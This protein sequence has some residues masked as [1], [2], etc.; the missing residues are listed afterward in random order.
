MSQPDVMLTG[1]IGGDDHVDFNNDEI[2]QVLNQTEHNMGS[3]SE[4]KILLPNNNKNSISRNTFNC[5]ATA[6]N[7]FYQIYEVQEQV[8]RSIDIAGCQDFD[9]I[10]YFNYT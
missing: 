8:I 6:N 3:E 1:D 9:K 5:T 10:F 4:Y 2:S 7:E